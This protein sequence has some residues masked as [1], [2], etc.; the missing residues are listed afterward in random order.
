MEAKVD[1]MLHSGFSNLLREIGP[2]YAASMRVYG[3][4]RKE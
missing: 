4:G 2:Q 1:E 3:I